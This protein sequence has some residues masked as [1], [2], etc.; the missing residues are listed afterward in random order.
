MNRPIRSRLV[1][2]CLAAL[3]LAVAGCGEGGDEPPGTKIDCH[4]VEED[5]CWKASLE[6]AEDCTPAADTHGTLSADGTSCSYADGTEIV[7]TNPVDLEDLEDFAW[8]FSV[9]RGGDACMSF[10][11][12]DARLW[13]LE[14]TLGTYRMYGKGYYV[15]IDCPDGTQF[16][17][18]TPGLLQGCDPDHLPGYA[19]SW[20]ATGVAFALSG[21]GQTAAQLV[22]DCRPAP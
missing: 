17:V 15:G 7:F 14:T 12:P 13:V 11:L 6:A 18:T 1:G 19:P 5:N 22:F 10:R 21:S 9:R 20:D 2:T 4:W 8:D 16:K 3:C